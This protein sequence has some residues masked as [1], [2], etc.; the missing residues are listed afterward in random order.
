MAKPNKQTLE[1]LRG[2]TKLVINSTTGTTK[3]VEKM[4]NT[5]ELGH[6]PFGKSSAGATKGITGMVYKS[7]ESGTKLASAS[8]E[9]AMKSITPLLDDS[10]ESSPTRDTFLS[11]INGVYGDKLL[12]QN[13]SL[14]LGMRFFHKQ[15]ALTIDHTNTKTIQLSTKPLSS[16]VMLFIHGLCMSPHGWEDNNTNLSSDMAEK[17][18]ITPI[19]LHYNTGRSITSNGAE[20]AKQLALLVE[21]WPV[22]ITQLTLVG[23]SMGGLLARSAYFHGEQ[24]HSTWLNITKTLVSIGTPHNGA[25]L[26]KG[27]AVIDSL[28][29]LS[30]YARPFTL[31]TKIRSQGIEDLRYGAITNAEHAFT[32]LPK[33]I[34]FY[35]VAATLNT[36][37][38]SLSERTIGD[39]LVTVNSA[40]GQ[41]KEPEQM[42][43]IP[44]TNKYLQRGIGHN[45]MLT[46]PKVFE[47]IE[48][49]FSRSL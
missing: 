49:W 19:Y 24:Q 25:L 42:L 13:N 1:D 32:P 43:T 37:K 23:H 41:H 9:L 35:A 22:P 34:R 33:N 30:P 40:F 5:I 26:E 18:G 47:K 14:A 15:Q 31:L 11:V 29:D 4:H 12:V 7:I 6:G 44:E 39:G 8:L 21:N 38:N 27:G 17:L 10:T 2:L 20:L 45:A 36:D 3:L 28:L 16:K 48:Q 46:E